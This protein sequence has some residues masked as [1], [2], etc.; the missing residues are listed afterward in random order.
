MGLCPPTDN[1]EALISLGFKREF[2]EISKGERAHMWVRYIDH[3]Y[4][5][6]GV[7]YEKRIT[8]QRARLE[9]IAQN[10]ATARPPENKAAKMRDA[11][12]LHFSVI[13]DAMA[14]KDAAEKTPT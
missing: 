3:G 7:R 8:K 1:L 10:S 13:A 12:A 9:V 2:P 5:Q 6:Q 11:H 14:A 4:E